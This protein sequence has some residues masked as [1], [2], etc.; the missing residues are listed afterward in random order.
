MKRDPA[1]DRWMRDLGRRIRAAR[2]AAG[3]S[4]RE[5]AR[6]SRKS[7]APLSASALSRLERGG[8]TALSKLGGVAVGIGC[9]VKELVPV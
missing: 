3:L 2:T 1:T 7:G 9:P 4:L 5:V 6:R 8:S